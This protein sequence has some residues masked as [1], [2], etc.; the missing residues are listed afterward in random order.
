MGII[1]LFCTVLSI[2]QANEGLTPYLAG[3]KYT[4]RFPLP[5]NKSIGVYSR[6]M[7]NKMF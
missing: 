1:R 6:E 4:I 3:Q 5:A 7:K 2:S